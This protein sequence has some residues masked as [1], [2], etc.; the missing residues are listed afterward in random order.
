MIV[1]G[2]LSST[3]F[4][5]WMYNKVKEDGVK[6]AQQAQAAIASMLQQGGAQ[7]EAR[8]P[9]LGGSGGEDIEQGGRS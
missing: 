3:G 6:R 8:E 1:V 2:A 4:G 7:N 5:A 9:L